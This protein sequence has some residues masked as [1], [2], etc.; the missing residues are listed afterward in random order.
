MK[1]FKKFSKRTNFRMKHSLG[2]RKNRSF[3]HQERYYDDD[4]DD[5]GNSCH[6]YQS[7][8][9]NLKMIARILI[10][11]FIAVLLSGVGPFHNDDIANTSTTIWNH[12]VSAVN[13]MNSTS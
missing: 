2:H 9:T 6:S 4:G 7:G 8:A 5:Y 3:K 12:I 11:V 10:L 13:A 1:K